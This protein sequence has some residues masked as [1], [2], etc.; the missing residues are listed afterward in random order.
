MAKVK[1]IA[2]PT[3][4]VVNPITTEDKIVSAAYVTF[5]RYGI[6][7][8]T[9]EDI[10]ISAGITRPT[11]YKYFISK[12]EIVNHLSHLEIHKLHSEVRRR[13]L[14]HDSLVENIVEAL[15]AGTRVSSRNIY[16]RRVMEAVYIPSASTSPAESVHRINKD[17]WRQLVE[18]NVRENEFNNDLSVDEIASWLSMSIAVLLIKVESVETTDAELRAFISRFIVPPLMPKNVDQTS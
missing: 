9:M 18:D 10:A 15:L 4:A 5:A 12:N 14:K 6:A 16:V 11:V 1:S 3:N 8:T 7:K 2:T 13:S 17:W